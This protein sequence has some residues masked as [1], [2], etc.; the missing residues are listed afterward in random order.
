MAESNGLLNR[1]RDNPLPR[2]RIPPSPPFFCLRV[3]DARL[4]CGPRIGDLNRR[5]SDLAARTK[6]RAE[7]TIEYF[8]PDERKAGG[9]YVI[10]TGVVRNNSVA[11]RILILADGTAIPLDDVISIVWNNDTE[12]D[13][14]QL[15]E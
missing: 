5:L 14:Q 2:V 3:S 11:E 12:S 4:S 13:E 7:V 15:E 8:V 10:V 9:M 1:R 6:D